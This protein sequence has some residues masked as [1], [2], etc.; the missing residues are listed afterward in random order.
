[1]R[2]RNLIIGVAAGVAILSAT[3]LLSKNNKYNWRNLGSTAGDALGGIKN[4]FSGSSTG[5]DML[6]SDH[7]GGEKLAKKA[8]HKAEHTMNSSKFSQA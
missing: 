2:N 7:S 5:S 6:S 3:L 8:R 1:M 4:R